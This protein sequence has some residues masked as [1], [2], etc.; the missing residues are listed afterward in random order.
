MWKATKGLLQSKKAQM[1]FISA[2]VWGLGRAGLDIDES[3]LI[4]IVSPL[5]LYIFGQ[6]FVD[7]GKGKKQAELEHAAE[8]SPAAT[9]AAT[10]E[11]L[12]E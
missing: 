5:W 4:G 11:D 1:A 2:A 8:S 6:S 12:T 7:F 10:A 9:A 3:T